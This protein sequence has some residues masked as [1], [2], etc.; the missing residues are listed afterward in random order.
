MNEEET[1]IENLRSGIPL[2]MWSEGEAV[3]RG[4]KFRQKMTIIILINPSGLL[5]GVWMNSFG[6]KT[7]PMYNM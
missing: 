2:Y 7:R 6:L 4:V 1:E 5:Y 3:F